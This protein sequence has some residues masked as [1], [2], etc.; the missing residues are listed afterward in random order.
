MVICQNI[1]SEIEDVIPVLVTAMSTSRR[2]QGRLPRSRAPRHSDKVRPNL[3]TPFG[4][5]ACV[6][7]RK[8]GA[9]QVIKSK[10]SKLNVIFNK[11]G[12]DNSNLKNA[13]TFLKL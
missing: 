5:K 3:P 12:F 11:Q 4:N 1:Q 6:L 13:L 8:G 2:S 7:V 10:Y 9:S